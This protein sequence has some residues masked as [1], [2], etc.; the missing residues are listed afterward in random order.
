M[1]E[2][3]VQRWDER[4]RA[5]EFAYGIE[6]N[7]YLKEQLEKF[8]INIWDIGNNSEF[9]NTKF[10]FSDDKIILKSTDEKTI[11][12]ITNR[13]ISVEDK[14]KN[15][16]TTLSFS[17]SEKKSEEKKAIEEQIKAQ[18]LNTEISQEAKDTLKEYLG[19][20]YGGKFIEGSNKIYIFFRNHEGKFALGGAISSLTLGGILAKNILKKGWNLFI[21][22]F[23]TKNNKKTIIINASMKV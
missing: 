3:W 1:N 8:N 17:E 4:Y 19:E 22:I 21:G 5:G 13:G 12:T 16:N 11:I 2:T 20:K 7:T 10:K 18:A 14:N 15:N 6:P 23:K 9:T